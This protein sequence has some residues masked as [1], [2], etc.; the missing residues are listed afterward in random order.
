MTVVPISAGL[1]DVECIGKRL[2]GSNFTLY[3]SR[4][5]IHGISSCLE[6]AMPV[7][8]RVLIRELIIHI[9]GE[10][11]SDINVDGGIRPAIWSI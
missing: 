4:R 9:H 8:A 1:G 2:A 7:Y 5:S 11:V 6:E 10:D 3:S